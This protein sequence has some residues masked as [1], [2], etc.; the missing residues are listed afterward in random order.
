MFSEK[1]RFDF[2]PKMSEIGADS[3]KRLRSDTYA[4]TCCRRAVLA[5]NYFIFTGLGGMAKQ[6]IQDLIGGLPGIDE[7]MSFSEMIK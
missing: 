7:A 2:F 5:Q 3:I 4:P 6:M 1:S